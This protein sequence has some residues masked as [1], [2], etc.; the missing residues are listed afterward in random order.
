VAKPAQLRIINLKEKDRRNMVTW[1]SWHEVVEHW[2]GLGAPE[3]EILPWVRDQMSEATW[4]PRER[5]GERMPADPVLPGVRDSARHLALDLPR[6][7]TQPN[8]AFK[9]EAF[10]READLEGFLIHVVFRAYRD[11]ADERAAGP[12]WPHNSRHVLPKS[13]SSQFRGARYED[14][15]ASWRAIV[16]EASDFWA[17]LA[18]SWVIVRTPALMDVHSP[19]YREYQRVEDQNKKVEDRRLYESLRGRFGTP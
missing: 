12:W 16:T 7:G 6:L 8:I 19:E 5:Y 14:Q 1:P 13:A 17:S 15:A 4:T 2:S 3:V 18:A 11:F 10:C 9:L